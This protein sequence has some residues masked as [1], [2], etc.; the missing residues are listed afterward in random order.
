MEKNDS[1]DNDD[2]K[3]LLERIHRRK[4]LDKPATQIEVVKTQIQKK[5][6]GMDFL[7]YYETQVKAKETQNNQR[8]QIVDERSQ[9]STYGMLKPIQNRIN[10]VKNES[11]P[12]PVAKTEKGFANFGRNFQDNQHFS[13]N[14]SMESLGEFRRSQNKFTG[15][16][17]REKIDPKLSERIMVDSVWSRIRQDEEE[18]RGNNRHQS[19]RTSSISPGLGDKRGL[20]GKEIT[21]KRQSEGQERPTNNAGTFNRVNEPN[22]RSN[23]SLNANREE[24]QMDYLLQ[25]HYSLLLKSGDLTNS[26]N[27]SLAETD[28][29]KKLIKDQEAYSKSVHCRINRLYYELG[30]LCCELTVTKIE[31]KYE[32]GVRNGEKMRAIFKSGTS[33]KNIQ[34]LWELKNVVILNPIVWES[35][36]SG[37]KYLLIKYFLFL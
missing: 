21:V 1:K 12:M 13:R 6:K 37:F 16:A 32:G 22:R 17:P 28:A 9:S 18:A 26:S 34:K 14:G 23:G 29:I 30:L 3:G 4:N 20:D 19:R 25:S 11:R 10:S 33:E 2:T 35:R 7:E 31:P 15:L 8:G 36:A 27:S 24:R 5:E